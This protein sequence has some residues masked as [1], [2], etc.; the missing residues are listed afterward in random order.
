MVRFRIGATK[1]R[2]LTMSSGGSGRSSSVEAV[3]DVHAIDATGAPLCGCTDPLVIVRGDFLHKMGIRRCSVC[4]ARARRSGL[5]GVR[6]S[7]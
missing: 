5:G 7:A 4:D 6:R 1:T 3:G 2:R